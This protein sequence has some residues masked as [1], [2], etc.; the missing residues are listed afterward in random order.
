MADL[1]EYT[2]MV[3]HNPNCPSPFE[4]RTGGDAFMVAADE[5]RNFVSYGKTLEDAMAAASERI[6]D[7]EQLKRVKRAQE[8][9]IGLVC[10]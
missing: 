10:A 1:R 9:F 4:V 8:P 6:D 7:H 2:Y 5:R 3:R